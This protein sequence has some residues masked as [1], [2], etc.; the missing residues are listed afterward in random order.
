MKRKGISFSV[1]TKPWKKLTVPQLGELISAYGFDGIEFPL[2][3]GFQVEPHEAEQGLRKLAEQLAAYGLTVFSVA[4]SLEERTFA[5]CAEAGIPL[6]RIMAPIQKDGYLASTDRLR[7]QLEQTVPLCAKY[8]VAVGIQPHF[9]HFVPDASGTMRLIDGFDPRHIGVIWDAAHDALA[10][11]RPEYGL[12]IVWPHL[13][14]INLKNAYY[15]REPAKGEGRAVWK[16]HFCGGAEGLGSWPEAADYAKRRGYAGAVCLSAE[17][18]DETQLDRL[19]RED[20]AY[21]KALFGGEAE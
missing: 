8:G 21:A 9:G 13:H 18:S 14:M 12:E 11:Q 3:E 15:I 10:G 5:G 20:L 4:G 2:R 6:I 1:F 17:Y 7:R 19:L 16:R